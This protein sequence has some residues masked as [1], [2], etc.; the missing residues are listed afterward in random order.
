M[1][2]PD[3]MMMMAVNFIYTGTT[4]PTGFRSVQVP[5]QMNGGKMKG[6]NA[7]DIQANVSF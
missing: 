2:G 5:S 7:F 4:F 6:A 1:T 3:I